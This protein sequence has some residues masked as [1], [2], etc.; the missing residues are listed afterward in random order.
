MNIVLGLISVA[1][2]AGTFYFGVRAVRLE[3]QCNRFSWSDV[4]EGCNQLAA[5]AITG[6]E[7][8]AMGCF[9]GA[10]AIVGNLMLEA[11][12]RQVPV[13]SILLVDKN[14]K[15][16]T[17]TTDMATYERIETSK[18]E[19]LVPKQ[20]LQATDSKLLLVD[21]SVLTG[22]SFA[23]IVNALLSRGFNPEKVKTCSLIAT[24]SS[25][26]SNKGPDYYWYASDSH[27]YFFPWGRA[28]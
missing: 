19:L 27:V 25:V 13:F 10:S 26:D 28:Y 5:E 17:A 18:W 8:D 4:L 3:K 14:N 22:D 2:V 24:Q 20:L 1:G 12:V 6:F 15:I 11:V 7:P 21:A 23:N 9:P 16:K